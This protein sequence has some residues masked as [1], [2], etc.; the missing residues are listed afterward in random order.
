MIKNTIKIIFITFALAIIFNSCSENTNE[1]IINQE[2]NQYVLEQVN[3]IRTQPQAYAEM[4]LKENYQSNKDN[5]AYLDIR[6]RSALLPLTLNDKL[7][8]TAS[9]YAKFLAENNKFGHY[10]NGTPSERCEMEGY[11]HYSGEN[12]AAASSND[13]NADIDAESAAIE[14]IKQLVIDEGVENLG[15]RENIMSTQHKV[16]GIGF[17]NNPKATYKNYFVQVFG[18]VVE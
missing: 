2:F 17:A 5:G 12:I 7:E 6:S 10:E 16:M 14:F 13:R 1:P 4:Y 3:L 9:K 18:S 15:H 8:K 11:E